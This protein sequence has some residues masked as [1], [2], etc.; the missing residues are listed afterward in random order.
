[1]RKNVKEALNETMDSGDDWRG[2]ASRMGVR[3]KTIEKIEAE[4]KQDPTSD[5]TD[6]IFSEM[7]NKKITDLVQVL[8]QMD[9]HD[10]LNFFYNDISSTKSGRLLK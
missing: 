10:V 6:K 1:M 7:A 3:R 2:V 9:R 4:Y 5:P 8:F